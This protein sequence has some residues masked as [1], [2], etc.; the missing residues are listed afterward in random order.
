MGRIGE[1]LDP[2]AIFSI[3]AVGFLL[4]VILLP[5]SFSYVEYHEYGLLQRKSTGKVD[6]TKVYGSGRYAVGPDYTFL[7]YRAD[8]HSLQL[9]DLSVFSSSGGSN[10]SIGLEFLLDIDLTYTLVKDEIGMLHTSLAS[11]Y[12]SVISSRA[13]DAVKNEAVFITFEQFFQAR[14]A[15]ETRLREAVVARW[16]ESPALPCVLDQF[17]LGRIQIPDAVARKQLETKLQNERNDKESFLQQ[18]IVERELTA[19]EV[20]AILLE[21]EAVLRTAAAEASLKR[22][23]AKADAQ[24]LVLEAQNTGL[25]ALFTALGFTTGE[26]DKKMALDYLR[27]LRARANNVT[28]PRTTLSATYLSNDNVIKTDEIVP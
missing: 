2:R 27:S 1:N 28:A 20:N 9:D 11:S 25:R 23:K 10:T 21:K 6:T 17:H 14:V 7:K 3:L 13:K 12:N 19:V 5:L 8:A 4:L 24:K 18:A 26:E 22:A 16:Q 15:V